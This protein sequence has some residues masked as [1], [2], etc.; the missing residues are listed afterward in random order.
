MLILEV[1][2]ANTGFAPGDTVSGRAGW[3]GQDAPNDASLRLF[4]YTSGK[5]TRDVGIAAEQPLHGVGNS[6]EEP[7]SFQ[8]PGTPYSCSGTLLSVQ[9]AVEVVA[10]H[11]RDAARVELVLSPWVE[12][13]RLEKCA[14]KDP[15]L[16]LQTY[17]W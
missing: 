3:A 9:W 5:G 2:D 13:P 16:A 14:I 11:G 7:F 17:T 1:N 4:W 15:A 6:H 10:R 8:L 12:A